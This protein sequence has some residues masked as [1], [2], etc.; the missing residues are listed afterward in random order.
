MSDL[1]RVKTKWSGGLNGTGELSFQTMEFPFS[2]PKSFNGVGV[3]TNPEEL[4]LGASASCFLLT[5]G[6]VLTLQKIPVQRL[7]M[8]SE[9][10]V[11]TAGG[12]EVKRITHFPNLLLEENRNPEIQTKAEQ[13][14]AKA[15]AFC[16]ISKALRGNVAV[17]VTPEFEFA[18]R[19]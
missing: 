12:L 17:Q 7:T 18:G 11:S 14:V 16:L 5:L 15:E 9:I 19:P 2:V 13:A 3:G 4:L 8:E 1:F 10:E 6:T